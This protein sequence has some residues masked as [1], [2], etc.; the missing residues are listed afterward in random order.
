MLFNEFVEL[1]NDLSL[2]E[3]EGLWGIIDRKGYIVMTPDKYVIKHNYS[4]FKDSYSKITGGPILKNGNYLVVFEF[5]GKKG[6][7][8]CDGVAIANKYDEIGEFFNGVGSAKV[9]KHSAW[10][11]LPLKFRCFKFTGK[12][13]RYDRSIIP[14]TFKPAQGI[15]IN[16]P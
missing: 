4:Y 10:Y 7:F 9:G 12:I 13:Q 16:R 11:I 6:A 8:G 14:G 1:S 15:R 3:Y 2:A 5:E